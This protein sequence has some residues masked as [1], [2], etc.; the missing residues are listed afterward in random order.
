M[1]AAALCPLGL[2]VS[3]QSAIPQGFSTA[4]LLSK[5]TNTLQIRPMLPPIVGAPVS[6]VKRSMQKFYNRQ[7]HSLQMHAREPK[8][9][10]PTLSLLSKVAHTTLLIFICF[11]S[12]RW[13][14]S[15]REA[16]LSF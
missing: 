7:V 6:H 11:L 12:P 1:K 5:R 8:M 10:V 15:T 9:K 3:R 2:E 14:V 4:P 13:T 16:A